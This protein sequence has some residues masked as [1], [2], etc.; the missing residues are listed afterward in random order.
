MKKAIGKVENI[1]KEK[2][3]DYIR[4][5]CTKQQKID[6][7]KKCKSLND[8]NESQVSRTLMDGFI[9]GKIKIK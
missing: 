8:I 7:K 5:K 1:L 2:L 9:N 6:F 3:N 4:F